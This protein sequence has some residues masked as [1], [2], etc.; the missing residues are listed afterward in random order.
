M[1]ESQGTESGLI[2]DFAYNILGFQPFRLQH[3]G[4]LTIALI[5]P[6]SCST[7]TL[8]KSASVSIAAKIGA[9]FVL[10]GVLLFVPKPI[11]PDHVAPTS[12]QI[13][14]D[15]SNPEIV[16]AF[17][18]PVAKLLGVKP[19]PTIGR[20]QRIL[21]PI[22]YERK[23]SRIPSEVPNLFIASLP[24]DLNKLPR[25]QQRKVTFIKSTLTLISRV[26]ALIE[27]ERQ[28]VISLRDQIVMGQKLALEDSAW[29]S[30]TAERYGLE[31][32][33]LGELLKRVD[34]VPP[35]LAIAQAAE[36]S[37]WGTSRFAREG[38]ALFGQRAYR[39]HKKG[40]VPKK[41]PD[42]SKFRVRAFDH[43]I[44]GVKAYAHNLNSHFAYEAFRDRRAV[45]RTVTDH[46]DGYTLAGSLLRYSE[47]GED[48]INTI[49]LIMRV[50]TLQLFDAPRL[51]NSAATEDGGPDA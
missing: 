31:S 39:E 30:I 36:E 27:Q 6:D 51:R 26:N 41:R 22:G 24:A 8:Q 14:A 11:K 37:G 35:S 17:V 7:K 44:D 19:A 47:R 21:R 18:S 9:M 38:N 43:L 12:H 34:I 23:N 3:F 32:V 20:E 40:I 1:C 46:I 28:R 25:V 10:G 2:L 33:D 42:G 13:L 4:C 29:L 15:R 45:M 50:N 49:R 5:V 16:S 48:Y